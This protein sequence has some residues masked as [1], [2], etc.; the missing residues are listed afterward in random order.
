MESCLDF[1]NELT[2]L[3]YVAQEL[4]SSVLITIKYHAELAGEGCEYTW[5]VAKSRFRRIKMSEK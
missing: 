5:G 4:N 2:Q 1:A 3:E